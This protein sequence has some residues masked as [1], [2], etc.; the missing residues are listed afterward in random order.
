MDHLRIAK[1]T[2]AGHEPSYEY[3]FLNNGS[4]IVSIHLDNDNDP[5]D[6]QFEIISPYS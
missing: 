1:V 2:I 4:S 6:T 5:V 3:R